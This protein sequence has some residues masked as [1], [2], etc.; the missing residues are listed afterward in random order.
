MNV[1]PVV[2]LLAGLTVGLL[3]ALAPACGPAPSTCS[4]STCPG[5]CCDSA[6][7]CQLGN[8]TAACG[9]GGVACTACPSTQQCS[10][11][12]CGTPGTGGGSAGGGTGG[13]STGGGTGGGS[14]GGG[15]GGG[16]SGGGTGGGTGGVSIA[17]LPPSATVPDFSLVT[18]SA[19]VTGSPNQTVTFT[20][21]SGPGT[22]R[23][24]GPSTAV[25]SHASEHATAQ[26]RVTAAA[27][28]SATVLV[29]LT[30]TVADSFEVI[31]QAVSAT[32]Y[33]LG[34]NSRQSFAA[35]QFVSWPNQYL[36]LEGV[37]WQLWPQ[38]QPATGNTI[39]LPAQTGT[40]R[41]YATLPSTNVWASAELQVQ[42]TSLP[43]IEVTPSVATTSVNGVVQLTATTSTGVGVTWAVLSPGGGGVSAGGLYSAPATP[44][45]Y[46]VTATP[47]GGTSERF[48]VATI[49]VR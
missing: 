45:V 49:V 27:S 44:G 26:V 24:L 5:G 33:A 28:A 43:S 38:G 2:S 9:S 35:A 30:L 8:T 4:S 31:P 47:I 25:Y 12:L 6:G 18:L 22:L 1:R 32:P 11:G 19:T 14:V 16:S 23:T 7:A 21:E 36:G 17:V 34:P 40:A 37:E 15:T 20:L 10:L 3:G 46:V 29:P 39:T 42:T 13:G 48:G 41:L